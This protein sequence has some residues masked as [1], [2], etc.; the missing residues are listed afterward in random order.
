MTNYQGLEASLYDH[1]WSQEDLDDRQ[2]FTELIGHQGGNCL[3]LGCGTGRTL[4]P[5]AE[6]GTEVE[7]L[8]P[9]PAMLE[10]CQQ[11]L[12]AAGQQAVLHEGRMETLGLGKKFHSIIIPGASFQLLTEPA[13][14]V[15]ALNRIRE[16]LEPGGQLLVSL[17]IP[18]FEIVNDVAQGQWRLHK[19]S[20]RESDGASVLCHTCTDIDRHTQL[21][22]VWNRYEIVDPA[23]KITE[24]E[25]HEMQLRY[26]HQNEFLLLLGKCGFDQVVAYADFDDEEPADG[27]AVITYRALTE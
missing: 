26:Y 22:K 5:L 4:I 6:A 15:R 11:K 2:F 16:H 23:G 19:Q 27:T 24:T 17:Y 18:W 21:L 9:S 25:L 14:A 8:D 10:L 3:D 12:E 13:D 1:F 7:G 20:V